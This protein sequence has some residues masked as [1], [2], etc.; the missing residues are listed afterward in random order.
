MAQDDWINFHQIC[1]CG[2]CPIHDKPPSVDVTVYSS[3]GD[4]P[5]DIIDKI[6]EGIN[7]ASDRNKS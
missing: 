3:R 4:I 2:A 6:I 7:K 5:E 1:T